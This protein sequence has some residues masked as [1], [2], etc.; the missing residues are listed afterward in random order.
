MLKLIHTD[1]MRV[2][3]VVPH[4]DQVSLFLFLARLRRDIAR[5]HIDF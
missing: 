3:F 2:A 5:K 1:R 4:R